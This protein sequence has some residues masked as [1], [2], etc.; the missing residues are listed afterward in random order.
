[1]IKLITT[2]FR[3]RLAINSLERSQ[4][5]KKDDYCAKSYLIMEIARRIAVQQRDRNGRLLAQIAQSQRNCRGNSG[6]DN[7]GCPGGMELGFNADL[8][9]RLF[10]PAISL[11]G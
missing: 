9:L 6:G 4:Y 8:L 10:E 1:M 2:W 11:E 3:N 7:D 5:D